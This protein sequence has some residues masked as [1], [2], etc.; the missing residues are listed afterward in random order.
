MSQQAIKVPCYIKMKKLPN[1][2]IQVCLTFISVD[3][4]LVFEPGVLTEMIKKERWCLLLEN[5]LN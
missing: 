5:I 3:I 4:Y 2:Q 1:C